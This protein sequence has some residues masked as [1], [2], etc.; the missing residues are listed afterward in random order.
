MRAKIYKVDTGREAWID[1][2]R[3]AQILK[4]AQFNGN[5][6]IV[7][8]NQSDLCDDTEAVRLAARHL[9]ELLAD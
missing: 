8:Q 4:A 7:L 1:Y 9:R 3:V 2:K 5:V 6:C